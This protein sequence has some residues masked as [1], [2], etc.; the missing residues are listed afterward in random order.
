MENLVTAMLATLFALL[1]VVFGVNPYWKDV[2]FC[3]E[4]EA[5][6]KMSS[7]DYGCC[8]VANGIC[9][10]DGDH[11]CPSGFT[12]DLST[13]QCL[14]YGDPALYVLT[15][16][17]LDVAPV[18]EGGVAFEAVTHDT[19]FK[20]NVEDIK[21]PDS[22]SCLDNETCCVHVSGGYGCCDAPNAN[23]C[24]DYVSCCPSGQ[25]CDDYNGKCITPSKDVFNRLPLS[26]ARHPGERPA[27]PSTNR[28]L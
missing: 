9:C 18:G 26:V 10:A 8:P 22:S 7:G 13:K 6:C 25:V 23:C 17:M 16:Q 27:K 3:K 15:E 20:D 5:V 4:K 2:N 11:C 21:C 12:C 19:D 1:P 24:D 28:G 14:Q